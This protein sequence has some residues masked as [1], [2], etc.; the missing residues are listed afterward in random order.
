MRAGSFITTVLLFLAGQQIM[1]QRFDFRTFTW[2][3]DTATVKNGET[4]NL[5]YSKNNSLVYNGKLS[6]LEAKIIYDFSSTNQLY[7]A[8]YLVTL[9]SKTPEIYVDNFQMLQE[10]LTGKY[11][12]P[13]SK[14]AFTINGKVIS[15]DKWASNLISDNLNLETKWKTA[16]T[17][18]TLFL[19]SIN[20][21]LCIEIRY[22]STD[23]AKRADAEKRKNII[24]DL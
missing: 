17:D 16:T 18:I 8:F 21:E 4:A 6:N 3:V 20:D 2:G 13:K 14:S 5:L 9:N 24:K 11:G 22:T 7:Q 23:F 12:Q 1:A 15:Q 19:Y 10:L